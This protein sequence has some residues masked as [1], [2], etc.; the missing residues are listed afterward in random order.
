[1]RTA[2]RSSAAL[3]EADVVELAL[4]DETRKGLDRLLNGHFGVNT[5]ALEEIQ[6]LRAAES[7]VDVV[8]AVAEVLRGGVW[9]ET[10]RRPPALRRHTSS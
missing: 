1:M 10:L 8:D 6:L 2:K 5:C 9:S 3:G 4:L 7:S